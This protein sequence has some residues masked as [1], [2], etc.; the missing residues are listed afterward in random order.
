MEWTSFLTQLLIGLGACFLG[1]SAVYAWATKYKFYSS[2]DVAWSYGFSFLAIVYLIQTQAQSLKLVVLCSMM[3]LWSW[4]LGTHLTVRLAKH[5]PEEDGRYN[6]LRQRW[7]KNLHL[8]FLMFFMS[9]AASIA[10]L[11]SPLTFVSADADQSLGG[12]EIAGM[13]LWLIGWVGESI[14]D[15]QLAQFKKEPSN[16]GKVCQVGLWRYSR[17]PNYF[18]EWVIW[19]SYF[20]YASGSPWGW[21]TIYCPLTMLYLLFKI[22]GIPETEKQSLRSR[23]IDYKKYQETTS[24][25]VPWFPKK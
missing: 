20:I 5:Y 21:I 13:I 2:V 22:T 19:V 18:F 11:G 6:D 23:P 24:V 12:F 7:A 3:I 16:K 8:I 17:H 1:M 9:Q 10:I 14:A 4:R 15:R 25:F